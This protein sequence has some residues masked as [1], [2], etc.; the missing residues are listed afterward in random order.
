MPRLMAVLF[1]FAALLVKVSEVPFSNADPEI[2][3]GT[4]VFDGPEK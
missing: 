3:E 1:L 2:G 4:P